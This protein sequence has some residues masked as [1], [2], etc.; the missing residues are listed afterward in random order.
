MGTRGPIPKRTEDLK[1]HRSRDELSSVDKIDV[2]GDV[3][4]PDP[5]PDWDPI[6]TQM[7]ESLKQSGQSRYYEPSDWAM[8][9]SLMDDLSHFKQSAARSAQMHGSIMTAL[10]GL[11][12]TEGDRRRLS[13]ELNR[14][15]TADVESSDKVTVMEQWKQRLSS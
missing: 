11:L 10:T 2:Y 12:V 9:Y 7:Y 4:I 5:D 13:L 14:K 3:V 6:A 15:T 8:A 1:G